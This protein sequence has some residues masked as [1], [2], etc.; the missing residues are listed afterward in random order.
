MSN[1]TRN[2]EFRE[3]MVLIEKNHSVEG[4]KEI[5]EVIKY[6]WHKDDLRAYEKQQILDTAYEFVNKYLGDT[7][8]TLAAF[9]SIVW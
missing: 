1:P 9:D 2:S 4:A 3:L 6:A 7:K 8:A 5:K